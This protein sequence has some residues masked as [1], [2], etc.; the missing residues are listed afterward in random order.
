MFPFSPTLT[1]AL[2]LHMADRSD[3]DI[4][5]YI[6]REV[7]SGRLMQGDESRRKQQWKSVLQM[8]AMCICGGKGE[9]T[10]QSYITL[11]VIQNYNYN[12][13]SNV[14]FLLDVLKSK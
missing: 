5:K 1:E 3:A 9:N 2:I 13:V 14:I 12:N 6:D 11:Y 8:K 10:G 7:L 4:A